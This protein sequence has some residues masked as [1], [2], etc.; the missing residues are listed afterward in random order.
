ML[1]FNVYSFASGLFM[2]P[3]LHAY[4]LR[5]L[6]IYKFEHADGAGRA[7]DLVIQPFVRFTSIVFFPLFICG[8]I[9][10]ALVSIPHMISYIP[11]LHFIFLGCP[12]ES[13]GPLGICADFHGECF[14]QPRVD[15]YADLA[16][17][18]ISPE[19]SSSVSSRVRCSWIQQWLIHTN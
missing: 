4:Y 7:G 5:A 16:Y 9:L 2:F 14:S 12:H 3:S 1:C 6:D 10:Y 19:G 18:G 15:S 13:L 8:G 11:L 17:S